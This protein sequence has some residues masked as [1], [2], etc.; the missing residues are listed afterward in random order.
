MCFRKVSLDL[1]IFPHI[2]QGC[3]K[4][5]DGKIKAGEWIEVQCRKSLS[6]SIQHV[7]EAP[8]IKIWTSYTKSR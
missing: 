6:E 3:K 5:E 8:C 2:V 7:K 1:N 4:W